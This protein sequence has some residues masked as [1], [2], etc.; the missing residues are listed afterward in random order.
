MEYK[1]INKSA[2]LSARSPLR[3]KTLIFGVRKGMMWNN[4]I[5]KPK[6]EIT[7]SCNEWNALAKKFQKEGALEIVKVEPT[8]ISLS[9]EPKVELIVEQKQEEKEVAEQALETIVPQE[10]L[11]DEEKLVEE[12]AKAFVRRGRKK[13]SEEEA[14]NEGE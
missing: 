3:N 10:Q 14:T 8:P 1:F 12:G 9:A 7:L 4:I 2:D 11:A 13:K 6:A 5:L